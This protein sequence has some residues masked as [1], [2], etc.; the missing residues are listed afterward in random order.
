MATYYSPRSV[1]DGLVLSLD[2][3]NNKSHA[4]NRF[5]AYGSGLVTENVAFAINGNGTFQ[6]VAAGTVIGGYTVKT[7]DVVYSY[8]LGANGCHYHGNSVPIP[9]GVYLTFSCDYLVTGATN[10]PVNSALLILENYGGNALGG[11]VN[12][13]NNIQDIWQ[14][15][16][17]TVGPTTGPGTQAMFLYPGLCG[18]RLADSGTVYFRNPLVEWK[19]TDSGNSGYNSSIATTGWYDSSGNGN[20]AVLQGG[21]TYSFSNGGCM[22]F[23]GVDDYAVIT[24]T[25]SLRPSTELTISMWLKA[26]TIPGGWSIL[27]GQNPYSGGPLIFTE[28]SAAGQIRALHYPNGSE[29]RCN[30]NY[31]IS[32]SVFTNAVFT[33]RTGDAIR[34]YFNGVASTTAALS[35]GTFSYNTSNAYLIG[36]NGG[37]WFNGQIGNVAFY[38]RALSPS[39]VLQN[40]NAL[41]GRFGLT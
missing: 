40:Y 3:G 35:A 11:Q 17:M 18:T 16:S 34:S 23:D 33:F 15:V 32:T 41:K 14:R 12:A 31:N 19:N 1:T 13:P 30:T 38:N 29:V 22:S 37:N 10:Y 24:N 8:G 21:V 25:A 6:R 9:S 2:A 28:A 27:F 20:N 4:R 39:E 36:Y 26:T 7:D 5:L